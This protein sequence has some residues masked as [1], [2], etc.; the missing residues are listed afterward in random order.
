LSCPDKIAIIDHVGSKAGI[1][2]YSLELLYGLQFLDCEGYY[3][4]N[5]LSDG[6]NKIHKAKVFEKFTPKGSV[7][8]IKDYFKGYLCAYRAC[9]KEGI[10][11]VILHSFSFGPKELYSMLLAKS[12]GLQITLIVHDI[13]ALAG[14]DNVWMRT[15]I[16]NCAA[17]LVVHNHFSYIE[18]KK[19]LSNL[20]KKKLVVIEHG[21]FINLIK[22]E[23][24]KEKAREKLGLQPTLNYLLLDRKS[25]V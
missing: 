1:D 19:L 3:Y 10:H 22:P 8:K 12:F 4:S 7:A 9:K 14:K 6:Y 16:L 20:N 18:L 2:Y 17:H 15:M 5:D 21:N 23:V 13:S 25:V 11:K 24:T